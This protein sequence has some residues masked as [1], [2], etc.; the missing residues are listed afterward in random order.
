MTPA[1]Q[2]SSAGPNWLTSPSHGQWLQAETERLFGFYERSVV[3]PTGGFHWLGTT[4]Q[5][6]TDRPKYLWLTARMVHC[7]AIGE[8]LGRPGASRLVAHGL[9]Y[10]DGGLRDRQHGG[11]FWAGGPAGPVDDDKYAYGHAFVLLA[12]SSA[13]QAGHQDAERLLQDALDTLDHHFW[14]PAHSMY[15]ERF[16]A[17][18][19]ESEPYRGANSHIHLTEALMAAAEATA[20]PELHRRAAGIADRVIAGFAAG[21][22]WRLPEHFDPSWRPLP[23]YNKDNPD[24]EFRP[25]GSTI[26]HWLEWARL[27]V[28][29]WSLD[30]QA[31]GW[32]VEAARTLFEKAVEEAWSSDDRGFVFTVDWN[33]KPLNRDRYHWVMAEATGAAAY[34]YRITGDQAYERW[35]RRFWDDLHRHFIDHEHGGWHHQ[36]D[37]DHRVVATVWAGKPD[38]YH[39]LQATLFPRIPPALGIAAALR[40][41]RLDETWRWDPR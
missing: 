24:N 14:E 28:Q 41:G 33:G 17:D 5:P 25:F 16:N 19:S 20:E 22:D 29:L 34:L 7:F 13:A 39:A 23:D 26:G 11:W 1:A 9:A 38:L 3:D 37:P 30:P 18:W 36:L 6:L 31:R 8:L 10:L 35:Y 15:A 40:T 4:G 21:N 2:H 27:L 32:M 12:A